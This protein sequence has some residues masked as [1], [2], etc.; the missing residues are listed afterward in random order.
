[1]RVLYCLPLLLAALLAPACLSISQE[2]CEPMAALCIDGNVWVCRAD[3][4]GWVPEMAC[5]DGRCS[6]GRCEID[7]PPPLDV[8]PLGPEAVDTLNEDRPDAGD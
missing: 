4:S 7:P 1:M 5:P 8:T 3:G 6:D 2:P